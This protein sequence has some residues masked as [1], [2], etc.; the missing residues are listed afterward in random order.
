[1]QVVSEEGDCKQV[2][3]CSPG[4]SALS[5]GEVYVQHG[6]EGSCQTGRSVQA[7][8]GGEVAHISL[9]VVLCTCHHILH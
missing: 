8:H 6:L 5:Q 4:K 9:L 2:L 7:A 1:M 3:A